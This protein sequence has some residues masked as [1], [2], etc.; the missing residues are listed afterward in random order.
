MYRNVKPNTASTTWLTDTVQFNGHILF[1]T[2]VPNTFTYSIYTHSSTD[3]I[4]CYL[5]INW[6]LFT[7]DPCLTMVDPDVNWSTLKLN[8]N[9]PLT[10]IGSEL[11]NG[12]W[13]IKSDILVDSSSMCF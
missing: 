9:M 3:E 1:N 13:S 4:K 10:L 2:N 8:C 12:W 11:K 6:T 5:T 7:G